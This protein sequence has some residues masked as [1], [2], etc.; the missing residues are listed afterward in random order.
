MKPNIVFAFADDWGR[1]ASAYGLLEGP[2]SLNNLIQT[3]NF[4]RVAREGVIFKNAFVPAPS[5]TPCR[6]SILS[7]QYFWQT[8]LGAILQGAVWDED[9]PTYPL[10][11]EDAGYHIGYTYKV[12]SPGTTINAPYG[13]ERTR[14]E[15]AGTNYGQFS[16]FV[17]KK[18]AEFGIDGAKNLL[19]D[20]TRQNFNA[21]LNARKEGQPFCYWW[22]PTNTHRSWKKG[23]GK[24]LWG[25][26]PDSLKGCLP[27]FL[28]DVH[29]IREDVCDYLGECLAVDAGLGVVIECLEEIGELDNT[30]LVVS[31]DH[32]IPGFPRA[33]CNLYDIGCEVA[34]AVR[35]PRFI[36][37]ERIVDDFI[38]LRDLAPTFLDAANVT[39]PNSMT[40]K[41]LLP[42]LK[43]NEI[44]QIEEDRTFVVTG[45]E[46]HVEKAREGNLPYPQRAIRT[47]E[48]LYI[49]NFA[50]DR[51]PAGDPLGLDDLQKEAPSFEALCSDTRIVYADLDASPTKAWMIRWRANKE[52]Q[53]S[54]ELGFGKRPQEEL[55]DLRA[56][57]HHMENVAYAPRYLDIRAVL[58]NK[59]FQVLHEND[60]P[61]VME[62]PCR[63]EKEPYAGS[64]CEDDF[65]FTGKA[66]VY[67]VSRKLIPDGRRFYIEPEYDGDFWHVQ[68]YQL[69]EG[70]LEKDLEYEYKLNQPKDETEACNRA[71]KLFQTR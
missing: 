30:L 28:P 11:L 27:T 19:L 21:F 70:S 48:F 55:Y 39:I 58:S 59:L 54:F 52:V 12:W 46:R 67:L 43:K 8:G 25:L 7:G 23:S 29:D 44:G 62:S 71:W 68:I 13:G 33:K 69:K 18:V 57:P 53:K 15:V 47:Q 9:I 45:R 35:W 41:S 64:L 14:Y 61:R 5:C 34:L 4:D 16:H 32:G 20:E 40:A 37:P 63:F 56:D 49:Y 17:T 65:I 3:P 38:N 60:D 36:Q 24:E 66:G 1:Y 10:V 22:G 42:I 2:N 50:P 31:G 26:E 51:W 6:S